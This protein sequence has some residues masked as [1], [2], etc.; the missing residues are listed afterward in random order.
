MS[1][2]TQ[3]EATP[4]S[5]VSSRGNRSKIIDIVKGIAITLVTYGHT[6]QGMQH[7]G[8]WTSA[9][10]RFSDAFVY[11]FHMPAF[12]FVA[13]LFFM[14]GLRKRGS[15]AFVAE[16]VRTILYP[17]F[18]WAVVVQLLEPI[19]AR[20]KSSHHPFESKIFLIS[21]F[22][23]DQ[24]WFLFTLF[25]CLMLAMLSRKLPDWLRFL[26]GVVIGILTPASFIFVRILREFCFLAAGIWVGSRI[27]VLDG[28]NAGVAAVGL[29]VTTI[30]QAAMVYRFGAA[31]H[32]D[33]ILLGMTGTAG[34]FFG[35]RLIDNTVVGDLF[36]WLGRASLGVFL[37]AAFVQGAAREILLRVFYTQEFW[38]QLLIPTITSTVLPVFIWDWQD[39]LGLGWLFRG[40]WR[41]EPRK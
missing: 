4:R 26:I 38:L 39:R 22:N 41:S 12:F 24:N 40:P 11:S 29:L 15:Q 23:G 14:S 30:F 9:K 35:A 16:K 20:F 21:L 10:Y 27:K 5:G 6:A 32:W 25:F 33:Y 8:W 31:N 37:L 34:L 3:I 18:L 36:A 2:G 19:M 28:M 17:Y 13:G 1:I 7:R